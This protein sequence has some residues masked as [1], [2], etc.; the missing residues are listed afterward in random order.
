[1]EADLPD[2]RRQA[3]LFWPQV[4]IYAGLSAAI[5]E[6]GDILPFTIA[7]AGL[8]IERLAGG[9]LA[10]RVNRA[11]QG[12][13]LVIPQQCHGGIQ[14]RCPQAACAFSRDRLAT[15]DAATP[16]RER[17]LRQFVGNRPDRLAKIAVR[18]QGGF[19]RMRMAGEDRD[20]EDVTVGFPSD[21][22]Q[23][24][25]EEVATPWHDLAHHLVV[26][27]KGEGWT[28]SLHFPNLIRLLGESWRAAIILQP[29]GADLTRCRI[30]YAGAEADGRKAFRKVL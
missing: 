4:W 22:H 25:W 10:A 5:P 29:L 1:M 8:H 23:P 13:C 21:V 19:I 26:A 18:E 7:D 30:A 27:A 15:I 24:W 16:E 3:A 20:A 12:G 14:L 17:L 28:G 2:A 11:Q 9:A 6:P